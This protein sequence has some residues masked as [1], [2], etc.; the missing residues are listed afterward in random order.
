MEPV[1]ENAEIIDITTGFT[2]MVG[3]SDWRTLVLHAR[4][5]RIKQYRPVANPSQ[6]QV[7]DEFLG[8]PKI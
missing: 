8:L 2:R 3:S 1:L 4:A 5:I 6:Q 7:V